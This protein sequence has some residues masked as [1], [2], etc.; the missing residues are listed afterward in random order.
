MSTEE[1]NVAEATPVAFEVEAYCTTC[2]A[3]RRTIIERAL[4]SCRCSTCQSQLVV[5]GRLL[6]AIYVVTNPRMPSLVKIGCTARPIQD[7]VAELSN[8]TGVPEPFVLEAWFFSG[9]PQGDESRIHRELA[10]FRL[11]GREFFEVPIETAVQIASEVCGRL[12][13]FRKLRPPEAPE[14]Q[15]MISKKRRRPLCGKCRRS[16]RQLADRPG[17]VCRVCQ[18]SF[19]LNGNVM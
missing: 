19:D 8:A 5:V 3:L 11:E 6:G 16:L 15:A 9:D 1:G 10:S 2:K 13:S 12:P 7:R 4:A 14:I 17:W 18:L